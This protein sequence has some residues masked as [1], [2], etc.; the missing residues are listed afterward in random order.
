MQLVSHPICPYVH[1]ASAFLTEKGVAFDWRPVDLTRKPDWFLALSP[2]G[3]VP[4]LVTDD[5][6]AIFESVVILEYLDETTG[7]SLLP[8]DPLER[9]RHR[10]W[11]EISNDLMTG[12][13]KIATAGTPADRASARRALRDT[14]E[15]FEQVVRGPWF[16]GDAL[17]LVD[18][19]A[20]PALIRIE[21]LDRWLQLALF[22]GLPKVTAWMRAVVE[23]PAFRDTLVADSD[24][25]LRALVVDHHAAA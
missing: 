3:K 23:R 24:D 11:I 7:P 9:A 14:L 21:R 4:V 19:A 10:M 17:S 2:R 20:G 13:Y 5:G 22:D 15:R 12:H 25:R 6:T 8:A 16:D 18:F 1:R